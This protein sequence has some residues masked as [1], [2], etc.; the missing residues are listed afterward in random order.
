MAENIDSQARRY[1]PR[2]AVAGFIATPGISEQI[3]TQL[4]ELSDRYRGEHLFMNFTMHLPHT[5]QDSPGMG[6][7]RS[8][9]RMLG[10]WDIKFRDFM[11]EDEVRQQGHS[12]Q[13]LNHSPHEFYDIV[14]N[15]LIE[16]NTDID[17]IKRLQESDQ[18]KDFLKMHDMAAPVFIKLLTL[19]YTLN[20]DLNR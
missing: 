16:S 2:K 14:D 7:Y 1:A 17:E 10:V 3:H 6:N 4:Q 9:Y 12:E 5:N 8:L 15:L 18:Q 19:G 20:G 11:T 13:Y